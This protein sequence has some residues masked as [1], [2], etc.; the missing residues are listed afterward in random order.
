MPLERCECFSGHLLSLLCNL[1]H[2]SSLVYRSH[3]LLSE[4]ST[5]WYIPQVGTWNVAAKVATAT[6]RTRVGSPARF[7]WIDT[8]AAFDFQSDL[9]S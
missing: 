2:K 8:D 1:R 6:A 5:N 7:A 4:F 3:T 9:T